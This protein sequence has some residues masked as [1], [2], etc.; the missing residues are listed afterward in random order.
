V[1]PSSELHPQTGAADPGRWPAALE[2]TVPLALLAAAFGAAST[3][4]FLAQ[5]PNF[6]SG[7]DYQ[8]M[9]V[10]YRAFYR[11]ALL[12]GHLPLWNPF[13][14]LGRPFLADI[15]TETLYPPNLLSL[16]L[17]PSAGA[18]VLVALHQA[19]AFFWGTRFSRMLGSGPV[20]AWLAGAG[21]ALIGPF[22]ARL[23][24]GAL[25][26]YFCACWWPAVLCLGARLQDGW[27][28]RTAAGFAAVSALAVLAG[29]PPFAYVE[30]LGLFVFLVFRSEPG[31]SPGGAILGL[32]GVAAAGIVGALAASAQL[33]PFAELVAQGSRPLHDAAFATSDGMPRAGWLSLVFR[34]SEAFRPN[35]EYDVYCGLVPLFAAGAGLALWRDR[36]ARGL[37]ALGL[38]GG[39]FAVG[40][41]LPVLG[42][43]TH[44]LPGAAALR[45]PSRYAICM[46]AA[47]LGL[48]SLAATR[49][50][51]VG[52][53]LSGAL[54][55]AAASFCVWLSP[56]VLHGVGPDY[57][58]S[59]LAIL[60]AVAAAVALWMAR[61]SAVLAAFLAAFC[62]ID[63]FWEIRLQAPL[64][65]LYG[66]HTQEAAVARQIARLGLAKDG[67]PPPRIAADRS[68]VRENAGMA[69]GFSTY[70][71]YVNPPLRRVW[72]YLLVASGTPWPATDFIQLPRSAEPGLRGDTTMSIAADVEDRA[73]LLV[74]RPSPD[75]RAYLVQSA[76]P[77]PGWPA[78]E[79]RM[80]RGFD[81]HSTAL[82]EDGGQ[83][84]ASGPA[85]RGAQGSARITR[86]GNEALAVSVDAPVPSLL[87]LGEAWYPGWR[88]TVNGSEAPVIPVN[89]WMRGVRVPAGGSEVVLRFSPRSVRAGMAASLL[90]LFLIGFLG[91]PQK[92]E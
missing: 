44:L 79:E 12:R 61:P 70:S 56:R 72:N 27:H 45:V 69:I 34:T 28:R 78:A 73:R 71:G 42:W 4:W 47:I 30:F 16:A 65:S 18:A 32:S 77:A 7:Y 87:V 40:D 9:H 88:A 22:A 91:R 64:Y 14:Q 57:V 83:A 26:M 59:Q 92:S 24:T 13:V 37:I 90:G 19:I 33:V 39:A 50:P 51:R 36:N 86:F 31:R 82:V 23:A 75:P 85:G 60:G 1:R 55:L 54:F 11:S 10:F 25:P 52:P 38:L 5:S 46:A 80:A 67:A 48:A 76:A 49:R 41:R 21:F 63:W 6:L 68:L 2:G 66:Y 84:F 15:E 43:A 3:A 62:V 89:G 29:N 53:L 17:G 8:R 20:P 58:A 74:L 81:V 35:W